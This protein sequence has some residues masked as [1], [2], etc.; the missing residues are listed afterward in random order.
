MATRFG[1]TGRMNRRSGLM[2]AASLLFVALPSA[3]G[4]TSGVSNSAVTAKITLGP[5]EGAA[6]PTERGRTATG[7]GN[8]HV[9][10]PS[11]DSIVIRMAGNAAACGNPLLPADARLDFRESL[12]FSI[13]FTQPGHVGQL[14]MSGRVIGLLSAKGKLS[15]AGVGGATVA[16]SSDSHPVAMLEMP[17]CAVAAGESLAVTSS[18]GPICVP[19]GAGCYHLQQD[20]SVFASQR[21]GA[22]CGRAIAEF[23]PSPLPATW[24]GP[25]YPFLKA[26]KSEFGF[27]VTLRVAPSS[28][29]PQQLGLPTRSGVT[30]L[31]VESRP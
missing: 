24:L 2:L 19:V 23:S 1:R 15:A 8:I 13:E 29:E 22:C 4:Q 14:T 30:K 21:A 10:Q 9:S 3:S 5:S 7:G 31:T 11:P 17:P 25:S 18:R 6:H 20:F 27:E 12:Q 28:P 26:D 16:V